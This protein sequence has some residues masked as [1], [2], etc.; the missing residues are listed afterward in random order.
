MDPLSTFL[1]DLL[2]VTAA[3]AIP[4]L[5]RKKRVTLLVAWLAIY[6]LVYGVL[7]WDGQYVDANQGGND[8][9]SIWYPAHCG[10]PYLAPTGRQRAA[11]NPLGWFFVPLVLA[12]RWTVHRTH[13][14]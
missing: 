11:L 5:L 6:S 4:V 7:T 8:N 10:G 9:R 3:V 1:L 12:D 13:I 14:I 2:G